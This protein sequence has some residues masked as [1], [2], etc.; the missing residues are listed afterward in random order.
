MNG[1]I[2]RLPCTAGIKFCRSARICKVPHVLRREGQN[3]RRA[4][5]D[6]K[7]E[8]ADGKD[9]VETWNRN[10]DEIDAKLIELYKNAGDKASDIKAEASERIQ[11]WMDQTEMDEK[12][13]AAWDKAKADGKLIGAKVEHRI[14]HLIADGRIAWARLL[15]KD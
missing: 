11:D 5:S 2:S 12:A 9:W 4:M 10:I 8:A 13:R 1:E 6:D 15:K 14:S 7:H 3:R